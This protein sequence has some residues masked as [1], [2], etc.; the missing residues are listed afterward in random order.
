MTARPLDEL[1]WHWGDA[2]LILYFETAGKWVAQRRDSRETM[3][4]DDPAALLDRIRQD[5][6]QRPVPRGI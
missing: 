6:G 4:A 3:S 2:Y 1:R 5:Y